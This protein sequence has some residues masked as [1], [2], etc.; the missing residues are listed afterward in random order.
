M[1]ARWMEALR[2]TGIGVRRGCR[3]LALA[4]P[5]VLPLPL[6]LPLALLLASPSQAAALLA[7]PMAGARDMRGV[8]LWLQADGPARVQIEYWPEERPA[9]VR[10]TR[11]LRLSEADDFAATLRIEDLD[12][13]RAYGYRVRLDGRPLA[14]EP[15][16]RFTT[17]ALWQWRSDPPDF[18][19][20]LGS[21][22]YI[23]EEGHDRPGSPYGGGYGIFGAMAAQRPDMVLWLGDNLYFREPDLG[24]PW[25]M[26]RRWRHDR[27][28]PEL[29]PLARTGHH[30]AIWDDHDYGPNDASS[31]WQFKGEALSLFRRYWA[32]P[33]Y[34]LPGVPGIFTVVSF[35]DVDFF[36]LDDRWHRDRDRLQA[37]AK[38]MLGAAQLRWLQNALLSSNARFKV[39][40]NGSQM[41]GEGSR[42][43]GWHHFP[44]E[45]GAFLEWLAGARVDG[46]LFLSGDR[47]FTELTRSE[48]PGNY[49]L[50]ELTC[51]P[52]T[53]GSWMPE[54]EARRPNVVP[55]TLVGE[56]NFCRLEFS[57]P[58]KVRQ[59]VIKSFNARGE[60]LW[61][62]EIR[63]EELRTAR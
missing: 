15:P 23:N 9:Q 6:A 7:G 45:R 53:A 61:R 10:R 38:T 14:G 62:Q 44:E 41:L 57:G 60:E 36:L 1:K 30:F 52:L 49:P 54:G 50:F 17:Q 20:V 40:A 33:S 42:G 46:V 16:L 34:G 8:S 25:A 22:S 19:V 58:G 18:A 59:L 28:L 29:Q 35:N 56:R 3:A 51:S 24:S 39:I 13:G 31:A 43:E 47:H 63:A 37:P 21:C 2:R 48:R 27:A 4:L 55:G 12:P 26:A 11:P 5:L 32:N